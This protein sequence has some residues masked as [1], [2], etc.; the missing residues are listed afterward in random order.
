MKNKT[1][2]HV[3][4]NVKAFDKL[5]IFRM[6]YCCCKDRQTDQGDRMQSP[7]VDPDIYS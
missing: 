6:M 1:V 2:G 5:G 7:E 4:P 3:L